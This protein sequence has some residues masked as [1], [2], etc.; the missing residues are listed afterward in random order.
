VFSAM[1]SEHLS[2]EH[3]SSEEVSSRDLSSE[4]NDEKAWRGRAVGEL[5]GPQLPVVPVSLPW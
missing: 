4:R 3:L 5:G 2:S 1:A